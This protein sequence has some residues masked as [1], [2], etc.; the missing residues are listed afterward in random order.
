MLILLVI[1]LLVLITLGV[2]VG[3][4]LIASA[5][6]IFIYD[7]SIPLETLPQRMVVSLDSFSLLAIPLFILAG[8][9][10]NGGGITS[11]L[12]RLSQT[13][14]GHIRGSLV[15]VSIV[16]NV[17]MSGI[18]GSGIADA[19]A[20][21][22][23]LIPEMIKRG[24]GRG[25]SAAVLG[26]AATIGPIIPPSIPM[27]IYGSI[28]GVSI[29]SLFLAG[30]IPGLI[31]C[32]GLM[33]IGYLI[34]KRR[35]LEKQGRSSLREILA[36][37]KSSA[38]ALI[39]PL[40]IV[41]GILTGIFTA[42]ESAVIAVLYAFVVGMFIHRELKWRDIPGKL[43]ETLIMTGVIGIIISAASPFGWFMA[44]VQGPQ[45]I[46]DLFQSLSSTPAVILLIILTVLLILGLFLEGAAILIITTP[47]VVPL[48]VQINVDLVHY[49]VLL[50]ISIMIGS[51]TPPVGVLMYVTSNI[52]KCTIRE[53][54]KEV[55]PFLFTLIALLIS[56]AL[57]PSVVLFL[58]NLLM[59]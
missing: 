6:F 5:L 29:G 8:A 46:V 45:K 44:F 47:V 43:L 33:L 19:A 18:S 20:T 40:V 15:H 28:A 42:T 41:G 13:L 1:A 31:M 9:L 25:F 58:P 55:L 22:T 52:A 51:I 14:V 27:I 48:L 23:T 10:M 56:F 4:S 34:S 12:V 7:G 38:F 26:S 16:S 21:G 32:F 49:G 2:P 57:F 24:Y 39:L 17:F 59:K 37:F 54:T 50:A 35:N 30:A 11:R 36:A 3:F 53:F